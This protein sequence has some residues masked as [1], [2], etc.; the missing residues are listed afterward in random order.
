MCVLQ[1][2]LWWQY[3][4]EDASLCGRRVE[5]EGLQAKQN[6]GRGA[7]GGVGCESYLGNES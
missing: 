3:K 5:G 6:E 2:K 7:E 4:P 1:L